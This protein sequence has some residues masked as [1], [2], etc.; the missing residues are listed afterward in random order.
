[1]EGGVDM[2]LLRTP[3]KGGRREPK[4][5]CTMERTYKIWNAVLLL[6][7]LGLAV[8]AALCI[9]TAVK[10]RHVTTFNATV[11]ASAQ[12]EGVL[13]EIV[14]LFLLLISTVQILLAAL[15]LCRRCCLR[16]CWF[17]DPKCCACQ[18]ACCQDLPPETDD[19]GQPME[20]PGP[21]YKPP[22]DLPPDA[23]C[24]CDCW[25][26]MHVLFFTVS[27]V[28][29]ASEVVLSSVLFVLCNWKGFHY[30][31][32]GVNIAA[33]TDPAERRRFKFGA[34]GLLIQLSVA[35]LM[36]IGAIIF[37]M[38]YVPAD[39]EDDAMSVTS[40]GS[41]DRREKD[42]RTDGIIKRIGARRQ[43]AAFVGQIGSDATDSP[44]Q[45]TPTQSLE[46]RQNIRQMYAQLYAENG[47]AVPKLAA[48]T[49][50]EA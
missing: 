11:A 28:L 30:T 25:T 15:A 49:M 4:R 46:D 20:L 13:E 31:F 26:C 39:P 33:P 16:N 9:S 24:G 22:G 23:S 27:G 40:Y 37:H 50:Q 6:F 14:G 41:D 48:T 7:G 1:M 8:E 17:A 35:V 18:C 5:C 12:T 42:S 36:Q 2:A 44:A 38:M 34:T 29:I 19:A 3:L 43:V 21:A 32:K 10:L 47:L 45:G